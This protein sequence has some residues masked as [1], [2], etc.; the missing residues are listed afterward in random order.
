MS[1]ATLEAVGRAD[2]QIIRG[3]SFFK[4]FWLSECE[5][6]IVLALDLTG[7]TMSSEIRRSPSSTSVLESPTVAVVTATNG[8]LT[9]S[10]TSVETQALRPGKYVW[11]LI[12]TAV[13]APTLNTHTLV[14]GLAV[15][16][17][18]PIVGEAVESCS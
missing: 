13:V 6:N 3:D 12:A 7:Y 17:D 11:Y 4:E 5:D 10:L 2:I 1:I 14:S 8:E 16:S 15:V 9:V 18:R